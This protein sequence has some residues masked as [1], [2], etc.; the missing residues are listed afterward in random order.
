MLRVTKTSDMGTERLKGFAH[1]IQLRGY[2]GL[3]LEKQGEG[4]HWGKL[5]KVEMVEEEGRK[6][7]FHPPHALSC[8]S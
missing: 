4:R 2:Y 1:T 3:Q 8:T 7:C 6:T 5:V